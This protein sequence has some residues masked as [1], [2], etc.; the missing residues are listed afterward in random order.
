MLIGQE[1]FDAYSNAIYFLNNERLEHCT[2]ISS[3]YNLFTN[4]DI[5]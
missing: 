3:Y 1:A 4:F 2:F 5:N